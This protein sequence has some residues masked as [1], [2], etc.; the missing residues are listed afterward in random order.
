MTQATSDQDYI[1]E[2]ECGEDVTDE[3]GKL[4]LNVVVFDS[5]LEGHM[6]EGKQ[7]VAKIFSHLDF[8]S[9]SR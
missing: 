5:R 3:I 6:V 4:V 1:A 7:L 2:E 9:L 8:K